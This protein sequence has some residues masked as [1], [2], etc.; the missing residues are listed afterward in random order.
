MHFCSP[1]N[2]TMQLSFDLQALKLKTGYK[3]K[4]IDNKI[5]IF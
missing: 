2:L 3:K 5:I 4:S 1:P